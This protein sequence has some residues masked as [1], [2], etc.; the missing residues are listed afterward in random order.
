M[1]VRFLFIFGW[2]RVAETL[3]NPFGEDDEDFQL[4][5]LIQRHLTVAMTIVEDREKHPQL[6]KDVFWDETKPELGQGNINIL[7]QHD[8]TSPSGTVGNL[9][10]QAGQFKSNQELR[11]PM[12]SKRRNE[13]VCTGL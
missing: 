11:D 4:V 12:A 8:L 6:E 13:R 10:G 7:C 3:Y 9:Q 1:T 5:E 2:L